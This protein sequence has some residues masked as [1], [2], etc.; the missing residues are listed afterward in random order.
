MELFK[1]RDYEEALPLGKEVLME[2]PVNIDIIYKIMVCCHHLDNKELAKKYATIYYAFLE[3][4]YNSGDGKGIKTAYVV[5]KVSD[6]Y[7]VLGDLDLYIVQQ[8]LRGTTDVLSIAKDSRGNAH[9]KKKKRITELYFN[10]SLPFAQ[11]SKMF[12]K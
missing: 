9:K 4:I 6:E 7:A 12:D 3:T 11:L 8:A 10:V 5:I 2:N 1:K